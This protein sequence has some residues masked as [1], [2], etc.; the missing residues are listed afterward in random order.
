MEVLKDIISFEQIN[1]LIE[2]IK[3]LAD[4]LINFFGTTFGWLGNEILFII[5]IGAIIAIILRVLG[6]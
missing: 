2:S 1:M 5:S 4:Q 3:G 6:R